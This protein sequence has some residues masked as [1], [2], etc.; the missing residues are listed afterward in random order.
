MVAEGVLSSRAVYELSRELQVEM[1]IAQA[2]FAMLFE[3]K[4]VQKAIL[5][6]MTR[7]PKPERD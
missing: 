4:P 7:E 1:P 6:L 3:G 2:V 5:D